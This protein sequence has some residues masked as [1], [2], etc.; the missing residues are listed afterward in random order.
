MKTFDMYFFIHRPIMGRREGTAPNNALP[1]V[2]AG[3]WNIDCKSLS[4]LVLAGR[5][6]FS[7]CLL[8]CT[9]YFQFGFGS[10]QDKQQIP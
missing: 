5:F 4:A 7:L 1:K 8:T 3:H 2:R 10:G 6:Q 9:S